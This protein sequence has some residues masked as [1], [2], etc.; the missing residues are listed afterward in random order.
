MVLAPWLAYISAKRNLTNKA[1]KFTQWPDLYWAEV[2]VKNKKTKA[3]EK[4]WC[5]FMLHHE[6]VGTLA[7]HGH[8][9]VLHDTRRMD[10]LT[11]EQFNDSKKR[12]ELCKDL[13]TGK[14][15][16]MTCH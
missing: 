1:L 14:E 6:Y 2:R 7:K 8:L 12:K 3:V 9:S 10:N 5:A 11:K 4:Q 16:E 15:V 13:T